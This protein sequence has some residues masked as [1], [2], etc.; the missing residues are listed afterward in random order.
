M[1]SELKTKLLQI[2]LHITQRAWE[3]ALLLYDEIDK[4]WNSLTSELSKEEVEEI[5]RI[6]SYISHLLKEK[7]EELKNE[8]KCLKTRKA[9]EK[10]GQFLRSIK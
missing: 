8:E 7:Y 2:E 5:Q 6:T 4:K 3:Q 1:A 10:F 9:Y